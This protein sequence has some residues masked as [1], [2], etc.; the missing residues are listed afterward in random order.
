[1][2]GRRGACDEVSEDCVNL[3][4]DGATSNVIDLGSDDEDDDVVVTGGAPGVL[5][6]LH[7]ELSQKLGSHERFDPS[8]EPDTHHV[9]RFT[10]ADDARWVQLWSS[11]GGLRTHVYTVHLI[12]SG[13]VKAAMS[14]VLKEL[15]GSELNAL[16]QGEAN[17]GLADAASR[18]AKILVDEAE[19]ALPYNTKLRARDQ[20]HK[21][22]GHM[23]VIVNLDKLK[24]DAG[25]FDSDAMRQCAWPLAQA[26]LLSV[27]LEHEAWHVFQAKNEAKALEFVTCIMNTCHFCEPFVK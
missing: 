18:V 15:S 21:A 24:R 4:T 16:T 1:M 25:G 5:R 7:Y 22:H 3:L 11:Q 17:A 26:C 8:K 27:P 10:N 2:E 19:G 14:R 13:T 20:S 12:D 9:K 23:L 6:L